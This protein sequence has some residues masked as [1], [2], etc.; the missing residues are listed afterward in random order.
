MNE[1][2]MQAEIQLVAELQSL[3][4]AIQHDVDEWLGQKNG[5]S[6]AGRLPHCGSVHA[7][8]VSGIWPRPAA[9]CASARA[10]DAEAVDIH[11]WRRHRQ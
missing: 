1:A 7:Q 10:V 5:S 3:S 9:T 11:P 2:E 6:A 8:C 4:V